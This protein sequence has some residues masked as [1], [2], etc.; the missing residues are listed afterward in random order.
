M[1]TAA[2]ADQRPMAKPPRL[3]PI[4]GP[5]VGPIMGAAAPGAANAPRA[6]G[7]PGAKRGGRACSGARGARA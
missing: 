4:V 1:F 5:I 3:G 6:T 2:A 7:N